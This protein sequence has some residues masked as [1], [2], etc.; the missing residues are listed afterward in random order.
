[1]KASWILLAV[2][3]GLAALVAFAVVPADKAGADGDELVIIVRNE[4]PPVRATTD[5]PDDPAA[6]G[7]FYIEGDI[8]HP[9]DEDEESQLGTFRCWGWMTGTTNVVSQEFE[10]DGL[11]K[12]EVQ[13]TETPRPAKLAIVGGTGHFKGVSGEVELSAPVRGPDVN[14]A[15]IPVPRF[16]ATFD[17]GD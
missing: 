11:G 10:I 4:P 2:C 17:L 9:D 15:G 3:V 7:A 14:D 8:F 12:L 16:S 6:A 13:G 5:D 1:M